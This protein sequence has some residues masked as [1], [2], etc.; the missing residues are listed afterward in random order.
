[1]CGVRDGQFL[2]YAKPI[3]YVPFLQLKST[4]IPDW[5]SFFPTEKPSYV[6]SRNWIFVFQ[7]TEIWMGLYFLADIWFVWGLRLGVHSEQTYNLTV[8]SLAKIMQRGWY[9]AY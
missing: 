5:H 2:C 8:L 1:M 6:K 9:T 4:E 7:K 3:M